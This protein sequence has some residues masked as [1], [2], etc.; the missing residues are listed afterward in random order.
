MEKLKQRLRSKSLWVAVA[1]LILMVLQ[2]AGVNVVEEKYNE[3]VN[4][5]L[6]ILILAGIIE[7]DVK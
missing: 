7:G 2:A 6:T 1:A 3:I 5:I 4:A